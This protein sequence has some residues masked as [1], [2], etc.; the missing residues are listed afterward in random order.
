MLLLVWSI[1]TLYTLKL[2][3]YGQFR[4]VLCYHWV[5]IL[6]CLKSFFIYNNVIF[7]RRDG[8]AAK[9]LTV[10]PPQGQ[11]WASVVIGRDKGPPCSQSQPGRWTELYK[12][13]TPGPAWLNSWPHWSSP[14]LLQKNITKSRDQ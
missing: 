1:F 9:E 8:Q 5:D 13:H 7:W 10:K 3:Y 6:S 4:I 12:N 2:Y 11:N 14:S